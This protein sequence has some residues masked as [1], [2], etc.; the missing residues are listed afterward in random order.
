MLNLL[1]Q[2]QHKISLD[3]AL[4]I[5][6]SADDIHSRDSFM[7]NKLKR[8][9]SGLWAVFKYEGIINLV[10]RGCTFIF[11][12]LVFVESYY[13]FKVDL[14]NFRDENE[15]DFLPKIGNYC[16][17]MIYTN[18]EADE[19]LTEGFKY[20]AYELN[21]RA[22]LDKE[23]VSICIFVGKEFASIQCIADNQ[24]GK[25]TI[26]PRPFT[27]DFEN[28]EVVGG[29]AL[30]VPKFRRLHLRRYCG[31]LVRKIYKSNCCW[32]F[33]IGVKNYPSL[34]NATKYPGVQTK[35]M[36]RYVKILWHRYFK[37]IKISP[38]TV[39]ELLEQCPDYIN[40]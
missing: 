10:S 27:V 17:R 14:S 25:A 24:T 3:L 34:A 35:A 18:K 8:T 23:I 11:H 32:V 31:Y 28:G 40:K 4:W 33:N 37:E 30:T 39:E 15:K 38:Q 1:D 9:F 7:I 21:L 13:L 22:Y 20:G 16:V 26:D 5:S 29:K 2:L 36:H 12:R 6:N 19:L